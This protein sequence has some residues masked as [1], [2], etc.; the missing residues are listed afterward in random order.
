MSAN[1]PIQKVFNQILAEKVTSALSGKLDGKF[2][3]VTYPAGFNYG[4]TYGLSA[5]YNEQT[6]ST[7]DSTIQTDADGIV[8]ISDQR[9]SSLL[10]LVLKAAPYI[11]SKATEK[12]LNEWDEAAQAQIAAV[13]SAFTDCGFK[14]TDPIPRG[15]RL[16]DVLTQLKSE[17]GKPDASYSNLPIYLAPLKSALLAYQA[18]ASQALK[19]RERATEAD[20]VRDNAILNIKNPTK[21]NGALETGE[22]S[23]YV[24]FDKLPTANQLIGSLGTSENKLTSHIAGD[25]FSGNDCKVHMEGGGTVSVPILGLFGITA[26]G[27]SQVDVG[28]YTS[29]RTSFSIDITYPG[30][31]TVGVVPKALSPD[32]QQGWYPLSILQEIQEKTGNDNVDGYKLAGTEFSVETLFGPKGRL[33]YLKTLVISQ[34]PSIDITFKEINIDE[35]RKHVHADDSVK[36]KLFGFITLGSV[37][38]SYTM[39]QINFNENSKSVTLHLGAPNVSGTI[40]LEQQVAHLLGGVPAYT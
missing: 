19:L 4:V 1:L 38:H 24:G 35:F 23:Y 32:H 6:L 26:S 34:E 22:A 2:V 25:S 37:K 27:S 3:A 15:G 39:D 17:Y 9:L 28:A 8:S 29:E 18:K 11:F 30:L 16:N 20:E 21:D 13:L 14:F 31:T 33:N 40:P 36:V 5:F 10:A 7:M 12:Q